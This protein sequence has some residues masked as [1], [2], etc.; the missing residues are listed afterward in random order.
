MMISHP[1]Q[2]LRRTQVFAALL[3]L[4]A[5]TSLAETAKKPLVQT[6]RASWYR[7]KGPSDIP[8]AAHRSIPLGTYV[9]VTNLSNGKNVVVKISDRGPFIRGR[10]IDVN[11]IA[12]KE[13]E[14]LRRGTARVRLEVLPGAPPGSF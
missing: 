11:R 1:V 14:I 2:T 8:T 4:I 13:L 6:G 12:A 3:F 5:S 10:V 9:R 7:G